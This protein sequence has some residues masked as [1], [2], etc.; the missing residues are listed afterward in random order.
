[1]IFTISITEQSSDE[2]QQR[3]NSSKDENLQAAIFD[4]HF[5]GSSLDINAQIPQQRGS[6][7]QLAKQICE[8]FFIDTQYKLDPTSLAVVLSCC[9][10]FIGEWEDFHEPIDVN[11]LIADKKPEA[12]SEFVLSFLRAANSRILSSEHN[13]KFQDRLELEPMM[14]FPASDFTA[15]HLKSKAKGHVALKSPRLIGM[16]TQILHEHFQELDDFPLE[17][18]EEETFFA[19]VM[20]V[21][22]VTGLKKMDSQISQR[23]SFKLA[24]YIFSALK[25]PKDDHSWDEAY[26]K[27]NF[28][29]GTDANV[30]TKAKELFSLM[31]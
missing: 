22:L 8:D 15:L 21:H 30:I 25:F 10:S 7:F 17:F 12:F 18:P 5:A 31:Q 23:K 4:G 26:L 29:R 1:M 9:D 2:L 24:A 13:D 19:Q 14:K 28:Q 6:Y 16:A 11:H 27:K 3:T 20:I